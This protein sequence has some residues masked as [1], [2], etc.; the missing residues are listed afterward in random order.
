MILIDTHVLIWF[1][2]GHKKLTAS[3]QQQILKSIESKEL[4]L[5]AISIWE[6]AVKERSGNL[7]LSKPLHT[8][9]NEIEAFISI[10]PVTAKILYDSVHL[11]GDFH[12]DP[13][14]R[15][16]LATTL[17]NDYQLITYDEKIL[18]YAKMGHVH[19]L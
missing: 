6:I 19:C 3:H 11:P 7:E 17:S 13:A 4:C 5:S 1:L 10:L 12:K 9:L 18:Q 2:S 16:I 15:I 14:D 8:L